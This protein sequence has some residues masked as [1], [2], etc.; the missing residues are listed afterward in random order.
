M[1]VDNIDCAEY[2][3]EI[4]VMAMEASRMKTDGQILS[5]YRR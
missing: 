4:R 3:R 5:K 2:T 1:V